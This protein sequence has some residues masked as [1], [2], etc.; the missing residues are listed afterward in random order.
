MDGKAQ[1]QCANHGLRK[2]SRSGLISLAED[3]IILYYP[4]TKEGSILGA[5]FVVGLSGGLSPGLP[6]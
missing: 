6:D 5:C 4:R 3:D 2:L 1:P